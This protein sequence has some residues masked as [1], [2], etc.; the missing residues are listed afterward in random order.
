M[1]VAFAL[2]TL[3]LSI[4]SICSSATLCRTGEIDYFSCRAKNGKIISVCGNIKNGTIEDDSWLQYRYGKPHAI[5][6]AYPEKENGSVSKFEGNHFNRYNVIDLRF[7]NGETLYSVTLNGLYSGEGANP[8]Y[9]VTG[10]VSVEMGKSK[11]VSIACQSIGEYYELF[12]E[13]NDSL[14]SHNGYNG[15]SDMLYYFYNHVSK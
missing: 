2:F 11:R 15:K 10:G 7:I 1:R 14:R 4:P 6:L 9:Y 13:L 12:A 3:A 5:K 8:R